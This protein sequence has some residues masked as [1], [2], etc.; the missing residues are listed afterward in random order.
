VR[1]SNPHYNFRNAGFQPASKQG[2]RVYNPHQKY[3]LK[4]AANVQAQPQ[5]SYVAQTPTFV[6]KIPIFDK[7]ITNALNFLF[8]PSTP[9]ANFVYFCCNVSALGYACMIPIN[10]HNSLIIK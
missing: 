4:P 6:L 5:K 8:P 9:K 3:Q 10:K 1:V 7:S 2:V